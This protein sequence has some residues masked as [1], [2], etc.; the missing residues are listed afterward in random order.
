MT[1][2]GRWLSAPWPLPSCPARPAP[3]QYAAPSDV[4]PQVWVAPA[5]TG[6][7]LSPPATITGL[8]S[9]GSVVVPLPICPLPFEPQQY[10]APPAATAQVWAR[11][12]VMER[13]CTA[14]WIWEGA[15]ASLVD[16]LPS[17]PAS[18]LPQQ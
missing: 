4:R 15:L 7:K 6:S 8:V 16:P 1:S 2:A 18:L 9:D 3:Q 11:P 10:A 13:N 17:W 14:A 5:A 12:A